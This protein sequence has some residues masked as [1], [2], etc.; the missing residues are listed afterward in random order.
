MQ[1]A[2]KD[3]KKWSFGFMENLN[4]FHF[5]WREGTYMTLHSIL[6]EYMTI[7]IENNICT[8]SYKLIKSCVSS[9]SNTINEKCKY[10]KSNK[11]SLLF[12]S[13]KI[14]KIISSVIVIVML[15]IVLLGL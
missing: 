8:V 2:I 5:E 15:M 6:I 12:H 7:S 3:K 11:L 4:D 10:T 13:C 9:F 1:H 14:F